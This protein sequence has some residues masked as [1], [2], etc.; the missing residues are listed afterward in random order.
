MTVMFFCSE[1]TFDRCFFFFS[2]QKYVSFL[3]FTT[4]L[5]FNILLFYFD[6]LDIKFFFIVMSEKLRRKRQFFMQDVSKVSEEL[7][8][9]QFLN[10]S[11]KMWR[12]S[13]FVIALNFSS[14]FKHTIMQLAPHHKD[15]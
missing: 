3:N 13:A 15:S 10:V 14:E 2:D 8:T 7:H 5:Q 12:F 9:Q 4:M 1:Y 6:L 11:D